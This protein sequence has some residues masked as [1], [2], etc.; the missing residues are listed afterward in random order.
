MP[1]HGFYAYGKGLQAPAGKAP[2]GRPCTVC[3]PY[4]EARLP[5]NCGELTNG[6]KSVPCGMK[7]ILHGMKSVPHGMKKNLHGMK[8]VP[9]G[10][11][12]ILHGMKS[13]PYGM[14]KIPHGMKSVPHGMKKIPCVRSALLG[15]TGEKARVLSV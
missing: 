10:M 12:K 14:E 5:G 3:F 11:K 8:S 9:H 2:E 4:A 15:M 7:K 1:A 6:M 13:V